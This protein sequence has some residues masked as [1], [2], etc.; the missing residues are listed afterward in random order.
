MFS[1]PFKLEFLRQSTF[2]TPCV[3]EPGKS[4]EFG[5]GGLHGEAELAT[6]VEVTPH[7]D[8]HGDVG[9]HVALPGHGMATADNRPMSTLA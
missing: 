1:R 9:A 3:G 5:S 4:Q 2:V 7:G 6:L 8:L